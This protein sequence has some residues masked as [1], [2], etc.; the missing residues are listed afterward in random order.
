M[1][2]GAVDEDAPATL[3]HNCARHVVG[4]RGPDASPEIDD[5]RLAECRMHRVG[6]AQQLERGAHRDGAV[7]LG[8]DHGG[9]DHEAAVAPRHDVDRLARVQ[10]LDGAAQRDL[11]RS[12]DEA[13]AAHAAQIGK[14]VAGRKSAAVDD[15]IAGLGCAIGS[16]DDLDAGVAHFSQHE[17]ERGRS[18]HV[19]LVGEEERGREAPGQLGLELLQPL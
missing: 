11:G 14:L 18:R 9:A 15:R 5:L 6:R 3:A 4:E 10:E 1:P 12:H 8:L 17:L 2:V 19:R 16:E 7:V 13:L